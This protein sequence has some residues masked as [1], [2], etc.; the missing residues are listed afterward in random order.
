MADV[1]KTVTF[2]EFQEPKLK[3]GEY[4]IA[5]QL[6][7]GPTTAAT[8]FQTVTRRFA[9][10]G[11]RFQLGG[12]DL[13]SLFPP[14]N[15]NGEFAGVLPH[16]VLARPTLPWLRDCIPATG[17]ANVP[18][19]AVLTLQEDEIV[20]PPDQDTPVVRR[21][22][23]DLVPAGTP[24]TVEG[25]P[26]SPTEVGKM[27]AGTV[28]YP[29][30]A[31][32]DYGESPSN[33]VDTIDLDVKFF[34]RIAPTKTD[35]PLLANVR[36]TDTHDSVDNKDTYIRRAIVLGNRV[37]RIGGKAMAF[38]V[39]LENLGDF[40]P[41]DNGNPSPQFGT[42]TTIRLTVLASWRFSV[43][44]G[45]ESLVALLTH[46][47]TD[48]I[49]TVR[50]PGAP[51]DPAKVAQ[52]A[53]DE[54]TGITS[55]DA[56][57]MV[58]N[59]L[60]AGFV[61]LAHHLREAGQTVSWY[62]GPPIPCGVIKPYPL[63][64]VLSP[65]ALLR[66]DPRMGMFDVSYAAAWQ[67]GQLLALASRAFSIAL[68]Q[69]KQ[70]FARFQA[71]AAEQQTLHAR[72]NPKGLELGEVPLASFL[73]RM[74]TNRAADPPPPPPVVTDFLAA[75]RLLDGVPFSYLVPDER[76]LPPESMRLFTL[77]PNWVE[78]I[79]D[80][81]MSIGRTS[82]TQRA[83]DV[84]LTK[85]V[86]PLSIRAARNRRRNDRPHLARAKA[87]AGDSDGTV[88]GVL[89]RSQ[90]IRGWPT[91]QI[92]GYS[93]T[94]D[95]HPPDVA[96]LRMVHLSKDVLLCLFDGMVRMIAIH[97]PPEQLHSGFET[98]GSPADAVT[99]MREI[100]G[101]EPGHQYPV[102]PNGLAP[103]SL[104]ADDLTMRAV[105]SGES[106]KSQLNTYFN[107]GIDKMTANEFALEM[108]KG[109]VRVEYLVGGA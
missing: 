50:M 22:A 26:P 52:A 87:Q 30:M 36:L 70:Q 69:W 49:A 89:I 54:A 25:E 109:V 68:F 78:A 101:N 104:R 23:A 18:W 35:L 88:A 67:L 106:I 91:L 11:P 9:V 77:D 64:P 74:Q 99:T 17:F 76:M 31:D 90:A 96:K 8:N 107:Q 56:D 105:D 94:D 53:V 65:D 48:G 21:T 1:E 55:G 62:R 44:D 72:L 39:S 40:L 34:S 59:A 80:G 29:G 46:L 43:T 41:D 3:A 57:A 81:A 28:S 42:A 14:P 83:R 10:L 75:L 15:A 82:E 47:N 93:D 5:A 66:Y 86:R 45:G 6:T 85:I 37:G 27:P 103:I 38:L 97:E 98:S 79:V 16:A 60:A 13:V 100:N 12:D 73:R 32:L 108:V 51:V 92:D 24:I 20:L 102:D 33:P 71:I 58:A 7:A 4:S 19:L 61:P 2:I 95:S 84:E 63:L